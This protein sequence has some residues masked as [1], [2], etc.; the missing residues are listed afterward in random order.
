MPA[1]KRSNST[2]V[3]ACRRRFGEVDQQGFPPDLPM[4]C[5]STPSFSSFSPIPSFKILGRMESFEFGLISE[6]RRAY[7]LAFLVQQLAHH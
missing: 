1:G 2:A 6:T 5:R 7:K 3:S 4:L